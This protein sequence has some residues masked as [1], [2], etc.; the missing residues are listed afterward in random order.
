M[1][2][3]LGLAVQVQV[4]ESASFSFAAGRIRN[5]IFAKPPSF[6]GMSP[7]SGLAGEILLDQAENL[8]SIIAGQLVKVAG[9]RRGLDESH[10]VILPLCGSSRPEADNCEWVGYAA[11]SSHRLGRMHF[12]LARGIRC[13]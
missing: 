9:E 1:N 7:R 13:E 12:N 2:V 4:A 11:S 6:L 5:P 10:G 3:A 8:L